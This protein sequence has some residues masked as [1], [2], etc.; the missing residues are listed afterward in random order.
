[1]ESS[2]SAPPPVTWS[3]SLF[4]LDGAVGLA[5]CVAHRGA[6]CWYL[7]GCVPVGERVAAPIGPFKP[8]TLHG[9]RHLYV[10]GFCINPGRRHAYRYGRC[11]DDGCGA[12]I[13]NRLDVVSGRA[14]RL[15]AET[16]RPHVHAPP[17][18]VEL[19]EDRLAA[20]FGIALRNARE[21]RRGAPHGPPAAPPS[22]PPAGAAPPPSPG[23]AGDGI[24]T[25]T[26]WSPGSTDG[27]GT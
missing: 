13:C 20:A 16:G 17:V 23:T 3:P 21:E 15:D 27:P 7:E 9:G 18:R 19:D 14:E 10:R 4:A 12:E 22:R 6:H 2:V 5:V 26:V 24:P 11:P 8:C 1:M 25:V